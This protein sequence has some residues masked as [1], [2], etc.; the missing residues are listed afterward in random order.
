MSTVLLFT[1]FFLRDPAV[2]I[3]FVLATAA[4]A[5]RLLRTR[6]RGEVPVLL[7][8]ATA[9]SLALIVAFTWL[10]GSGGIGALNPSLWDPSRIVLELGGSQLGIGAWQ[11]GTD[12]PLNVLLYAPAGLTLSTLTTR[13]GRAWLVVPAL[14]ALS[15]VTEVGQALNGA[16]SGQLSDV[17]SNTIG[18]LVG[19]LIVLL[20]RAS[21]SLLRR[22][23]GASRGKEPANP[24]NELRKQSA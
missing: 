6:R 16:R 13:L 12:G 5:A 21:A 3:T 20:V 15:L 8:L 23:A 22:L 9:A 19:V 10:P 2:I 4:I 17:A 1:S 18:A 7:V 11:H 24:V 14:S